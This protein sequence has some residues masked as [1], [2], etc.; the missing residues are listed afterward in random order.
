MQRDLSDLALLTDLYE[1]T[2]AASYHRHGMFAPAT[3]S[4]FIREY[5]PHRSYFVSAGLEEVLQFLESFR[6]RQDD[7]DHLEKTERFTS[8][9]LHYLSQLR[10]TGDVYAIPEGRLFFRDEP[11][12]EVTGPIIEAQIVESFVINA[13]NLQVAIASKAARCFHAAGGRGL[14]DFSLRRTQGTDAA[15]KVARAS[16]IAGFKGSS[17]VLA[18]KAYGVPASGTMAHSFITSFDEEIDAFRAFAETF[19]KNTVLLVDTYDTIAGAHKAVIVGKEMQER[20]EALAGVRLDSGDMVELSKQVRK[21][22]RE[23]GL[24]SVSIFASGGFDEFKIARYI[25]AGC[26]IDAFG[27]GTKMG[28][29]ADAPY[30]DMAYKL[31][32]YDRRPVLKLS[33]G[34]QTLV[35]QKQVFRISEGKRLAKDFIA[36]RD[37]EL[38][39][40]PLLRLVMQKGRRLQPEEPLRDIQER[41]LGEFAC[42]DDD[43]KALKNPAKYSVELGPALQ[44]LQEVIIEETRQKELGEGS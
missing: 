20:G 16:F 25:Q 27:V 13:I 8:D 2:M 18:E 17:N 21:I 35:S 15:M 22:L 39:G 43:C 31:V 40:E 37:E 10:F 34:K 14:V 9:F 5:A 7:L 42:L 28:V 41:F 29:S 33:T 24:G 30:N 26:E 6:F 38:P 12:L 4:L 3:F 32:Q 11:V 36:L 44:R 1:L 19:P 23:A